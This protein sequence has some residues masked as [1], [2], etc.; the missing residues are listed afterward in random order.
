VSTSVEPRIQSQ[1][2]RE[3]ATEMGYRGGKS[4]FDDFGREVRPRF[5]AARTFQRTVYR[6]GELVLKRPIAGVF[7]VVGE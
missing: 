5:V 1:R 7:V 3:L 4:I 6:P 2:L